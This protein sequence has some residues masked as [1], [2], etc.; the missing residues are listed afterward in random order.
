M[1]GRLGLDGVLAGLPG[2]ERHCHGITAGIVQLGGYVLPVD[3]E[4]AARLQLQVQQHRRGGGGDAFALGRDQH[5]LG[6]FYLKPLGGERVAARLARTLYRYGDLTGDLFALGPLIEQF[7]LLDLE[8]RDAVLD[9]AG[10]LHWGKA[11]ALAILAADGDD[12]QLFPI[13]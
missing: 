10:A 5:Q 3:P 11:Y 12:L 6:G 13:P 9:H 4:L 1:I 2:G 8:L 7:A